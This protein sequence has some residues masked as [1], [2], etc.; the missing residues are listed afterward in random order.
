MPFG[1]TNAPASFQHFINDVRWPFLD[2]FASAYLDDMLMFSETLKEHK[3]HVRK[4]LQ[5]LSDA[6]LH[7]APEKCEFHKESVKYLGF[8]ITTGGVAP[9]PAKVATVQE[10][11]TKKS[12][13]RCRMDVQCFLGFAWFY[14]RFIKA[15]SRVVLPLT[16]LTGEHVPFY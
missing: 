3:K 11:G 9:D 14:R 2:I 16:R 8:I 5:A 4:V 12:P 7:L 6:G 1:L 10:W 15:Y 13:I